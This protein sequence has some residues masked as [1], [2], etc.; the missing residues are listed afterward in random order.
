VSI[1]VGVDNLGAHGKL[2][3]FLEFIDRYV[4]SVQAEV[5]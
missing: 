4:V 5:T 2:V 1:V 3:N